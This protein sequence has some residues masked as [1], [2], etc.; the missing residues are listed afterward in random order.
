MRATLYSLELSHP[1]QAARL[2]LERKGIDHEVKDL[3]REWLE[4]N[5]PLKAKHVMSHI[6]AM[7]GGR[8]YDS[9]WGVRQ[10]GEGEYAQ[11]LARRFETACARFG[12][13]QRERFQH[14]L[15]LFRPPSLGPE[16]LALL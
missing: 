5:E 6:H 2:M 13:N 9:R 8:D 14:N 16:Q 11:L 10:R 3:F 4:T 12:L 1:S 15:T 7:R